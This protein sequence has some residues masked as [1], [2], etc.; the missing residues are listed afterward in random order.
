MLLGVL[1]GADDGSKLGMLVVCR[2]GGG[3]GWV[4]PKMGSLNSRFE[5][6][7]VERGQWASRNCV[8]NISSIN[9]S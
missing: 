6:L 5:V 1:L 3:T 4:Q 7:G 8:Q 2:L 9:I